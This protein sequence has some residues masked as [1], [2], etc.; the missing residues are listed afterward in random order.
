MFA[1][2]QS[3]TYNSVAKSLVRVSTG[4]NS[5]VYRTA[6]DEFQLRISHQES[7]GRIRHLIRIDRKVIAA[8]PLTAVNAYVFTGMYFVVDE[9]KYGFTDA[10][11]ELLRASFVT[12]ISA[13]NVAKLMAG[14]H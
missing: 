10:E 11:H 3:L 1:D 6:D 4:E 13:A 8:D 14:E 2:P 5:S 7:K 12:L 9:P